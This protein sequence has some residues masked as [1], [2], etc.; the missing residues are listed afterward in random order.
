VSSSSFV[1]PEDGSWIDRSCEPRVSCEK[2]AATQRILAALARAC[3]ETPN[4]ALTAA[5]LVTAGWPGERILVS[6]AKNRLRVAVAWLRK[7]ARL[8]DAL[9]S[10]GDGYLLD[11][12]SVTIARASTRSDIREL[13]PR[14]DEEILTGS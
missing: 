14:N 10:V 11:P 3:V 13:A 9:V 2:R 12:R 7:T 5:E 8:G 4:R 1:I 6:A